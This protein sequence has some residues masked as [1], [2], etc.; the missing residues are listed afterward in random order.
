MCNHVSPIKN[1]NMV[2]TV[3]AVMVAFMVA[4]LD[5]DF[6]RLLVAKIHE[7]AFKATTTL[8]FCA[9]SSTYAGIFP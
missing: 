3:W 2:T 1:D 4:E 7:R 8:P 9:L 6:A 5:I